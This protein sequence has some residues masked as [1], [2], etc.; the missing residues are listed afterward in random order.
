MYRDVKNGRT[1]TITIVKKAS[2]D[3]A[4]RSLSF[5]SRFSLFLALVYRRSLLR[6]CHPLAVAICRVFPVK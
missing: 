5:D 4:V 2:G 3:M 6:T 1:R